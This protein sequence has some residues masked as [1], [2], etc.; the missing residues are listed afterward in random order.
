MMF[1]CEYMWALIMI[2]MVSWY[3]NEVWILY[4]N[5]YI[6]IGYMCVCMDVVLVV[7]VTWYACCS[8]CYTWKTIVKSVMMMLFLLAIGLGIM[9]MRMWYDHVCV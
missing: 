1:I 4:V 8:S 2:E 6:E 5:L 7:Y 9:I 3:D